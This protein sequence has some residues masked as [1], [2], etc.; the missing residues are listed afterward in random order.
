VSGWRLRSRGS[1]GQALVEPPELL[2]AVVLDDDPAS[3]ARSGQADLCAERSAQVFLD[4]LEIGIHWPRG[5]RSGFRLRFAQAPNEL[6]GLAHGELLADDRVEDAVLELG[7]ESAKGTA[8][9]LGQ[10]TIGD[11]RLDARSQVEES[12]RVG[13]GRASTADPIGDIVLAEAELVDQ[14]PVCLGRLEGIEIFALQVLDKGELELVAVGE[15]PDD[16]RDAFEAGRMGGPEPALAGDELVA[17][18]GFRDQDRLQDTVLGDA[19]RERGQTVLI[20]AFAGL[21]RVRA[22]ARDRDLDGTALPGA[23]LRDERC[24]TSTQAL[25]P[26]GPDGHEAAAIIVPSLDADAATR[27]SRVLS[28]FA[29]AEYA[30]APVDSGA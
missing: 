13:H 10:S 16:G 4:P 24:E 30:D 1:S 9:A 12:K 19:R 23:A 8:V 5:R 17:V 22:D 26:L 2:V 3:S 18:N 28:S 11:G 14:L 27:P 6:L 7:G 15:L 20:E 29:R 21:M 25:G